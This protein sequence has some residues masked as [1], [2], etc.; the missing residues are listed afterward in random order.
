M[1]PWPTRWK[2]R[3][4]RRRQNRFGSNGRR[5]WTARAAGAAAVLLIGLAGCRPGAQPAVLSHVLGLGSDTAVARQVV[6][7]EQPVPVTAGGRDWAEHAI[8]YVNVAARHP[9]TYLHD[10]FERRGGDHGCFRTWDADGALSLACS[11]V[12]FVGR[13]VLLPAAL[14]VAPPW[15]TQISRG[16]YP[17]QGPV[18][19]LPTAGA[20]GD[21][22][23]YGEP[24]G[25]DRP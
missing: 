16:G 25:A 11:P 8:G 13:T 15:R 21:A 6:A 17:R 9:T 4:D 3:M 14:V 20:L 22:A 7:V 18:R 5:G 12:L 2:S 24:A 1:T 19:T 10:E 23:G